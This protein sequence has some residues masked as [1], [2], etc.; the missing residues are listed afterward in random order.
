MYMAIMTT[1]NT[2]SIHWTRR[3]WE[4]NS[5]DGYYIGTSM[6]HHR[7]YN[8]WIKATR[9][10]QNTNTVYFQHANITTPTVMKEDIV[11]D[12]ATRLIEA[13]KGNYASVH[14]ETE[15]E[16]LNRLSQVFLDA[17]KKLSGIELE[18]TPDEPVPR[19]EHT[20]QTQQTQSQPPLPTVPLPRVHKGNNDLPHLIP[21]DDSDNESSDDKPNTDNNEYDNYE[22]TPTY[23]TR[24]QAAKHKTFH[25]N[26]MREAILSAVEMSL[27]RLNPARLAQRK[28]LLQVLCEIAGAVMDDKTGK[29][30]EYKQL[31]KRVKYKQTWGRAFGNKIGRLAQ[32]IPGRVKGTSTFFFIEQSHIPNDRKKDV[33]YARICCNVRPE[34]TNKPNRCRITVGGNRIN[35]PHEVATPTADLFM[36][37]LLLNSIILTEGA[38]FCSVDIKKI[39]LCTPLKRYENKD[40]MVFIEIQK[41][42]YSLLQAGLLAQE[43]LEQCLNKHGY[44]QSTRTPGLWTHKWQPVQFTLVVDDFGIKCVGKE[45]LQHL[46]S[47]LHEHY[48][49]SINKTGSRYIG[50][51]FDWDYEQLQYAEPDNTSPQLNKEATRFIQEVTGTF[52]YYARAIDSTMLTAL[53]ALASELAHPMEA[54]M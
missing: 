54:T 42:M 17:N 1:T 8:T 9:A 6:H 12:A 4:E 19:V 38:R 27:E 39:Y 13:I 49:I 22:P 28:F 35:Y 30:M 50:I 44:Y 41:G 10:I 40:G 43:L 29:L 32:G 14:N 25:S 23:N 15:V 7:T 33:T 36:V 2:L 5:K 53:S 52:L 34:K 3:S 48:E 45:N 26:M 11:A 18:T 31:M 51:H 46:T 47:I 37:K 20:P 21:A 16:A 24:T